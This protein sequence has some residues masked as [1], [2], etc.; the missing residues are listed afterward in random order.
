ML[1]D[2]Y[3]A[4]VTDE[5]AQGVLDHV[6]VIQEKAM[7]KSGLNTL[8]FYGISKEV[9]LEKLVLVR[10]GTKL[11]KSYFGPQESI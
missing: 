8:R 7:L 9:V 3:E 11:P 4:G 2:D 10:K 6:R 5:W 1:R